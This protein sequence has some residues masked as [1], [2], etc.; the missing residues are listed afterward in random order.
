[1]RRFLIDN[2]L[3]Q[4]LVPWL[5]SKG[6]SAQHVLTRKLAQSSDEAIWLVAARESAV[7]ISKDEDF[8]RFTLVRTEPVPVLW[9]R[10]GNCRSTALL[11]TMERAWPA[12]NE[13]LDAGARLIEI[14]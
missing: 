2:Q 11:A 10:I 13:Q 8:A 14:H 1:V 12:I 5:E 4:A 7:I 3:P 6:S 9:L